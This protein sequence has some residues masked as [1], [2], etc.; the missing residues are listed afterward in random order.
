MKIERH[1]LFQDKAYPDIMRGSYAEK[2][3]KM[4]ELKAQVA[5]ET[6][7]QSLI[8]RRLLHPLKDPSLQ[9]LVQDLHL[10]GLGRRI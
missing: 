2:Q 10:D 4:G 5:E 6:S 9:L 1:G 7:E 8:R 3:A